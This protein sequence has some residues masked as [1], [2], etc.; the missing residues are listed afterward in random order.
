MLNVGDRD[1]NRAGLAD[2]LGTSSKDGTS[3]SEF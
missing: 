1:E 2:R 3:D